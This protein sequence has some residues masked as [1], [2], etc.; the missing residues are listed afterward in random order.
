VS[1]QS[2]CSD[3][4]IQTVKVTESP[5]ANIEYTDSII[6]TKNS[7]TKT[8]TFTNTSTYSGQ[9][10]IKYEWWIDGILVSTSSTSFTHTFSANSTDALPKIF[11]VSLKAISS[12]GCSSSKTVPISFVP[13][14][15]ASIVVS[16]VASCGNTILSASDNEIKIQHVR[17]WTWTSNNPNAPLLLINN[18]TS[19]NITISI[20]INNTKA[21]VD[22]TLILNVVSGSSCADSAAQQ[23]RIYPNPLVDFILKD[24][25]CS[26]ADYVVT[27]M[28]DPFVGGDKSNMGFAWFVKKYINYGDTVIT[29]YL[30]DINPT[31]NLSNSGIKDSIYFINLRGTSPYG[32]IDSSIHKIVVHP[33]TFA[34]FTSSPSISCTPLT[35]FVQSN[36][37]INAASYA[38]YINNVFYSS[39]KIPTDTVL[40]KSGI[41][42]NLKLVANSSF[43]C[44]ADSLTSV[45]TTYT[46]PT[47]KF[48]V[49]EASSCSGTL[50]VS[51]Y[52]ASIASGT[53]INNWFW[54][55]GDGTNSTIPNPVHLYNLPGSYNVS[56]N[57]QDG[58]GCFSDSATIKNIIIYGKPTA[59]FLADNS[60]FGDSIKFTNLSKLGFGSTQ[61]DKV[62]WNFGDGTN[63]SIFSP[64]HFYN[65]PGTYS[66]TLTILS[67]KSCVV[68]TIIKKVTVFGKPKADF[69]WDISCVNMPISFTN[70]SVPGFGEIA[71]S[72]TK[73]DFGNGSASTL[74]SPRIQYSSAG[75]YQISLKVYNAIC[76]N[77]AD[78]IYKSINIYESRKGVRYP[79][80][81]AVYG[82]P[83]PL[84]ALIGGISYNWS[85]ATGL[86]YS[87]IK[88]PIA[89]YDNRVSNKIDYSILIK[90]S[91]GCTINDYQEVFIFL[92]PVIT[93][94]SAFI[95][96]GSD[97]LNRRF[98]PHY[99][100]IN[101]LQNFR[102][103][104]RWGVEHFSTADMSK[105]WDG[106][107]RNGNPLPMETYIWIAVGVDNNG[108]QVIGKGNITLVR[109]GNK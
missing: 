19:S 99:I 47:S 48:N 9:N 95:V 91:A 77:L 7:N 45:I 73:W 56:L 22:Y 30:T 13:Y 31:I 84:H 49:S 42:Y 88:D 96:D 23:I 78:T 54:D 92:K 25:F 106:N 76:S 80:V 57:V 20:P 94:P 101:R 10:I 93:A 70:L 17:K 87:N 82:N 58:R 72:N 97:P 37:S 89:I 75:I 66:V 83:Q 28:S 14:P 64:S 79:R 5:I 39:L 29:N 33:S 74:F 104:D 63:S 85:P 1:N 21:I 68:D 103:L 62:F 4:A 35:L 44:L 53:N 98:L 38:W 46:A 71:F 2:G 108:N 50:Q 69:S 86:D 59:N 52:N 60:C 40:T 24:T 51:F 41:R 100:N 16:K 32:C 11:S 107:D 12:I 15:K 27:N 105:Y 8:I 43:G 81:E 55:F 65:G 67:D 3:S 102:I 34:R 109:N 6:C 61:F 26:N 90:D 18:D 36:S